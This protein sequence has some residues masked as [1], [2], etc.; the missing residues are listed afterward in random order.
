VYAN[1]DIDTLVFG[2]E[3]TITFVRNH[4]LAGGLNL[5]VQFVGDPGSCGGEINKVA[6]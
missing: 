1:L 4:E 5:C 6:S 3:R 2:H